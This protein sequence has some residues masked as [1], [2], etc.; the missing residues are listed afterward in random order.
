MLQEFETQPQPVVALVKKDVV[1]NVYVWLPH[2]R[3]DVEP[4]PAF[5]IF[6]NISY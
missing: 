2:V 3:E 4:Q 5:T 1:Y 6:K